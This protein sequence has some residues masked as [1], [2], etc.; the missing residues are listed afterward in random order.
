MG[1]SYDRI[2][3]KEIAQWRRQQA[4][5]IVDET[6]VISEGR[7]NKKD[8]TWFPMTIHFLRPLDKSTDA[9]D[10]TEWQ[11]KITQ[12]KRTIAEAN[13]DV[14][15]EAG[16]HSNRIDALG[17]KIHGIDEVT[18]QMESKLTQKVEVLTGR[19]ND[20]MSK[21]DVVLEKLQK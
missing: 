10:S 1:D 11:G 9:D 3:E 2:K 8:Y 20:L 6:L 4:K 5:S 17:L 13:D 19:V 16:K 18:K 7:K 15:K 14:K 12:L 21:M